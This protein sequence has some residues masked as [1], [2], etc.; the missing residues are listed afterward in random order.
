MYP[1]SRNGRINVLL[2]FLFLSTP[3]AFHAGSFTIVTPEA[4]KRTKTSSLSR[5]Y[6][7]VTVHIEKE[8]ADKMNSLRCI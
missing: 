7:S 5:A 1:D 8:I 6:H 2:M 4:Y 3:L